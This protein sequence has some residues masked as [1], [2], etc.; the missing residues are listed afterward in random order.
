LPI[1]CLLIIVPAL[2]WLPAPDT[3]PL[4][5]RAP[6]HDNPPSPLFLGLFMAAY[7]CA[8]FGYVISATFIVA[9]VDGCQAWPG[10]ARWLSWPSAWRRRRPASTGI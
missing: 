4:T 9:I 5:K 2:A 3:S 8:G 1:A 10:R 7:F 6:M